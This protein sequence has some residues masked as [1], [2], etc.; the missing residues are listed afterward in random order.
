MNMN[1]IIKKYGKNFMAAISK[2]SSVVGAYILF[3]LR[4]HRIPNLK[5]PKDFNEKMTYLKLND[6]ATNDMVVRCADKYLVRDYVK[7]KGYERILNELYGVYDSAD[8]IDFSKLP[9]KFAL[10][11]T[12][13]CAYNII[14]NDKKILNKSD[15]IK[16]L[17]SWLSEKYGYATQ[18]IHYTKIKPRII[19]ES[20]LC[21]ENNT[22]PLDYKLYCFDGE[23][24]AIKVSS[25][26]EHNLK[27]NYFDRGWHELTFGKKRYRN[28][29]I[30][31]KPRLLNE[32]IKIAEDL[33]K[34]FP[35]VR[36]D[37]YEVKD[38]VI[39]GELTFTPACCC[40]S[41]LSRY[42]N[43]TLGSYLNISRNSKAII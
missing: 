19:A 37:L 34:G 13:G 41:E 32:M 1:K 30:P 18:E 8:Q 9:E 16:K 2:S 27:R 36:V 7:E 17:N 43:D 26:R 4:T 15:S 14:C 10:R 12:H 22:L 28:N 3:M 29:I 23:V 42:G 35:F 25:D 33:S 31:S 24:K 40:S 20:N 38:K 39:F 11:C 5:N 21:D 6:Y